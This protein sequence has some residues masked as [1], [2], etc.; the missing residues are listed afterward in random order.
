MYQSILVENGDQLARFCTPPGLP[1]L[2]PET[3]SRHQADAHW[4]LVDSASN[5]IAR[6]SLWWRNTPPIPDRRVG[7]IGHYAARNAEAASQLLQLAGDQLGEQGC[8]M[9]A[10]PMD[11]NTWRNYRLIIKR[12]RELPFFLEPDNPNDWPA[13]FTDNGFT[14]LSHY[15][16]TLNPD[17]GRCH[18]DLSKVARRA[19]SRG[20]K[21]RTFNPD[22]FEAELHRLYHIALASFSRNFLYTPITAAEFMAMYH[23]LRPYIR[24]ELILIAECDDQPIGFIF[25]LPDL[26]QAQRAEVVDTIIIKTVAVHPDHQI[27]GLGSLLV[28]RCQEAARNLGYKRA[29]HALMH[30]TNASRKISRRNDTYPIRQYVLFAKELS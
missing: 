24:F 9:A 15:F 21:I 14:V 6:C 2:N 13:H 1:A 18:R 4:L 28:T 3:I 22:C 20:I 27:G 26:L 30:E 8:T 7:L 29:I 11:G 19:A 10:G 16:S 12:S 5:V 17:L 25:A 23:A